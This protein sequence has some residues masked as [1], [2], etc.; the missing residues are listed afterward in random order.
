MK[1]VLLLLVSGLLIA[2]MA[3]SATAAISAK[4]YN[5]D[6]T[7]ELPTTLNLIDGQS[8]VA[9]YLVTG[10]PEADLPLEFNY[11]ILSGSQID[12]QVNVIPNSGSGS[13]SDVT[14]VYINHPSFIVNNLNIQNI[15]N[16]EGS[17]MDKGNL[18]IS[19]NCRP[20]DIGTRYNVLIPIGAYGDP[21]FTVASTSVNI[22]A[23]PEF[24]SVAL[25]VAALIG[26]VFIFGRKKEG[27]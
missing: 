27:L 2:C 16:G 12:A 8:V 20:E 11:P 14:V 26:L 6:G 24:P 13:A 9:S 21:S 1:K 3:G 15:I 23:V 7:S 22:K 17:Y 5:A 18:R 10:I 4:L 25:P 19:L